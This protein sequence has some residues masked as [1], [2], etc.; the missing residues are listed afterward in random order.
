MHECTHNDGKKMGSTL[1][2]LVLHLE[3]D[4]RKSLE[5]ISVTPLQAGALLFLSRHANAKLT[6]AATALGVGLP[7]LSVVVTDLV[8]KRWVVRRRSVQD[9]RAVYLRL[10][11]RGETLAQRVEGQV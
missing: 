3:G 7:T 6:D 11:R 5:P 8:R 10:S 1:L 9:R 4:T 2:E